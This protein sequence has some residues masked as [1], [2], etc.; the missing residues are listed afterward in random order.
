MSII[1]LIPLK[2]QA[3]NKNPEGYV[4]HQKLLVE[5]VEWLENEGIEVSLPEDTGTWDKGVDLYIRG[6]PVDL[7]SFG[8]QAHGSSYTWDSPYYRGR[9]RPI[10]TESLTEWFVHPTPGPVS[11]WIAGPTNGL[12]TSKYGYAPYYFQN[13]TRTVSKLVQGLF[14]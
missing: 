11:E 3:W 5:L 8:L 14:T 1:P 4:R 10:Y 7:K 12:R 13:A 9:S 6:I 2:P